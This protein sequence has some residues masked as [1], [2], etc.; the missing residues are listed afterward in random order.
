MALW[1]TGTP[2]KQNIVVQRHVCVC[3]P[4]AFVHISIS[5][6]HSFFLIFFITYFPQL[7]FQYYPKT[8]PY[9]LPDSPTDHSHFL[10]LAFP[11]T[12][13]FKVCKTNGPLFP[14]MA[15]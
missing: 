7:H 9:P 6:C 5:A 8:P 11:C 2:L 3:V 1:I 15:D 12:E 13:A 4:R 14:M 10:A